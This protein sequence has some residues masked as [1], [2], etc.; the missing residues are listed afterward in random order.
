MTPP[1]PPSPVPSPCHL[2]HLPNYVLEVPSQVRTPAAEG[3]WSAGESEG[4]PVCLWRGPP[5]RG[6]WLWASRGLFPAVTHKVPS[7][8]ALAV[9]LSKPCNPGMD[10][11]TPPPAQ[12]CRRQPVPSRVRDALLSRRPRLQRGITDCRARGSWPHRGVSAW[13]AQWGRQA[14]DPRAR[15]AGPQARISAFSPDC[16]LQQMEAELQ[17]PD[18]L[19]RRG[20]GARE[21]SRLPTAGAWNVGDSATG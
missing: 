16:G 15:H 4:A 21:E 3:T 13:S 6:E 1:A 20:N 14:S 10:P 5:L 19:G 18:P 9:F 2:P 11:R 17:P 7:C 8:P 12:A